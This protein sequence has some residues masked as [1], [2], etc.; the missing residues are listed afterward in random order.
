MTFVCRCALLT[1]VEKCIKTNERTN[2]REKEREK[3]TRIFN[4]TAR[5]WNIDNYCDWIETLENRKHALHN[6]NSLFTHTEVVVGEIDASYER[7]HSS[8]GHF[9]SIFWWKTFCANQWKITAMLRARLIAENKIDSLAHT[10]RADDYV[11]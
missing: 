5:P 7:Q 1:L 11:W 8:I 3:K 2:D 10:L 9:F 4:V 6:I